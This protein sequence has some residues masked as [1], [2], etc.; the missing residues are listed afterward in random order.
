[1]IS[2]F[3]S[4]DSQ[5]SGKREKKSSLDVR[6]RKRFSE[7]K[8]QEGGRGKEGG[9]EGRGRQKGRGLL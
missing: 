8:G 3:I 2:K 9:V 5:A 6:D 4:G 7:E 1:L